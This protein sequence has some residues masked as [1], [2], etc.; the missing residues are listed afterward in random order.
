M[1]ILR[2]EP[3]AITIPYEVVVPVMFIQ[4]FCFPVSMAESFTDIDIYVDGIFSRVFGVR[5]SIFGVQ[6]AT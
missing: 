3:G 5:E 4:E 2:Y 1:N 6:I